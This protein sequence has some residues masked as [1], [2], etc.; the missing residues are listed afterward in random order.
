MVGVKATPHGVEDPGVPSGNTTVVDE[1]NKNWSISVRAD[2]GNILTVW[3]PAVTPD[4]L[5][6]S[7]VPEIRYHKNEVSITLLCVNAVPLSRRAEKPAVLPFRLRIRTH[8]L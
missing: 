2:V 5:I 6:V 3:R 4:H 1:V 8:R 7:G